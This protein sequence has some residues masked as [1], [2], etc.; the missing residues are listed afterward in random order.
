LKIPAELAS[1]YASATPM[2]R[3]MSVLALPLSL[4]VYPDFSMASFAASGEVRPPHMAA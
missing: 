1:I 4:T 2:P 3:A